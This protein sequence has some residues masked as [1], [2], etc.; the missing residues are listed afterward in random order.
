MNHRVSRRNPKHAYGKFQ[1]EGIRMGHPRGI[2]ILTTYHILAKNARTGSVAVVK[3]A[4][5]S[6]K[7]H[8]Y[9]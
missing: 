8:A 6:T 1:R 5:R 2:V 9:L 3:V 4:L 7:M